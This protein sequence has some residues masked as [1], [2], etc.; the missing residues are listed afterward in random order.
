VH[1]EYRNRSH[2]IALIELSKEIVIS[3]R[4]SPICLPPADD[5]ADHGA[6]IVAG[7]GLLKSEQK[8]C[9]TDQYGPSPFSQCRFPFRWKG[10]TIHWCLH[11]ETPA[12]EDKEDEKE[13]ESSQEESKGEGSHYHFSYGGK[14]VQRGEQ[15]LERRQ[16]G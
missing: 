10:K 6:G 12:A 16:Q 3:E 5:F 7:W 2:D 11:S 4:V 8:S 1:P 15:R 9:Y 14:H 13:E